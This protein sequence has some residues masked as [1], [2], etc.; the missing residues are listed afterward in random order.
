[1]RPFVRA[2]AYLVALA[3]IGVGVY[4]LAHGGRDSVPPGQSSDQRPTRVL[5]VTIE[6]QR[7]VGEREIKAEQNDQL[8]LRIRSDRNHQF[9]V[10]GYHAFANLVSG[11]EVE[12]LIW[13]ATMG[14]FPIL[15]EDTKQVVGELVV[16]AAD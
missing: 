4:A 7:I 5:R 8:L 16:S 15:L 1:M 11:R 6:S 2:G 10:E 3:T 13:T 12:L 14:V 9:H